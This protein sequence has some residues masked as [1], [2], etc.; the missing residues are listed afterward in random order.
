MGC[1]HP[2]ELVVNL[3]LKQITHLGISQSQWDEKKIPI[4]LHPLRRFPKR[5]LA[6]LLTQTSR[7]AWVMTEPLQLQFL[8]SQLL[9][10]SSL[11]FARTLVMSLGLPNTPE[12]SPHS[13]PIIISAR[14]HL[15]NKVPY[16][17]IFE[18]P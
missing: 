18:G 10:P 6:L 13:K 7:V 15:P 16:V 4:E 3:P 5:I 2:P 12:P 9:W 11:T 1:L 17:S 14:S 8:L